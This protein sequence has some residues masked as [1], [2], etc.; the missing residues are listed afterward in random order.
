MVRKSGTK[1]NAIDEGRYYH[2]IDIFRKLLAKH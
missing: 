1:T 2:G